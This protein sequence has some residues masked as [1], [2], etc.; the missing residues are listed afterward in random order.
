MMF[1]GRVRLLDGALKIQFKV[2]VAWI[3]VKK[4]MREG[5]REGERKA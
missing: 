4:G 2:L 1:L 5:G 3:I